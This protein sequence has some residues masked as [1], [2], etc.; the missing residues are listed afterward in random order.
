MRAPSLRQLVAM[1]AT[2]EDIDAAEQLA[3][4]LSH[5]EMTAELLRRR[6]SAGGTPEDRQ[7]RLVCALTAERAASRSALGASA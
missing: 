4:P 2:I 6:L 3:A 7:H 1:G 5:Q